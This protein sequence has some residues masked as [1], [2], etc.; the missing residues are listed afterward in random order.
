MAAAAGKNFDYLFKLMI[1]GN[2]SVGKTSFLIR[3]SDDYFTSAFVSTVGIDFKL[4]TVFRNDKIIKLQVWDTAGQE[5]YRAITKAYYREAMGFVLMYDITNENSYKA[6]ADW[7]Q[8]IKTY[9]WGIAQVVLVGNKCDMVEKRV[10]TYE[11]GKDLAESLGFAFFETSAKDNINV[12]TAFDKLIDVIWEK[13]ADTIDS[14]PTL[15]RGAKPGVTNVSSNP[16]S[17]GRSCKC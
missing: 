10:V 6:A 7:A 15:L 1:I 8:Q 9:S 16:N 11:Q 2:A 17:T 4:K 14:H 13:M 12:Q 3:Y 5:R